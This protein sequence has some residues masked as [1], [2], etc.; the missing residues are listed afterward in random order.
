MTVATESAP[1]ILLTQ[2]EAAESLGI[3]ERSLWGLTAPRGPIPAVRLGKSVRYR[4]DA[5]KH[6]AEQAE[7]IEA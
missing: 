4:I 7:T 6:F 5:L 1:R 2:R 3:C